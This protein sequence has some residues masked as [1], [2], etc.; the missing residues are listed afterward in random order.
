MT[1][2]AGWIHWIFMTS[3]AG[4]IHWIFMTSKLIDQTSERVQVTKIFYVYS[5]HACIEIT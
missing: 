4:W 1:S 2:N 3:N 5:F